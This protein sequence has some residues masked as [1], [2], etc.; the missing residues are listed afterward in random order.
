MAKAVK[1]EILHPCVFDGRK[2]LTGE[3]IKSSAMISASS[4]IIMKSVRC[5]MMI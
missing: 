5:S 2:S 3:E 4:S 1:P